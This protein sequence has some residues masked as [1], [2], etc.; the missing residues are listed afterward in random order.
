[1]LEIGRNGIIFYQLCQIS[2]IGHQT[3]YVLIGKKMLVTAGLDIA[4]PWTCIADTIGHDIRWKSAAR[5]I[6]TK[7]HNNADFFCSVF[8]SSNQHRTD[9]VVKRRLTITRVFFTGAS[10]Y[11]F[12]HHLTHS[13]FVSEPDGRS[14]NQYIS[15]FYFGQYQWPIIPFIRGHTKSYLIIHNANNLTIYS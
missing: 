14:N 7:K 6:K 15:I 1:M 4:W 12:D 2:S 5:M 8:V 3:S 9:L 13:R 10:V 11:S